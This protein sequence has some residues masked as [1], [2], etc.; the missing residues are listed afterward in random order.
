MKKILGFVCTI[1][2]FSNSAKSQEHDTLSVR[3]IWI[4]NLKEFILLGAVT[5]YDMK[6]TSILISDKNDNKG[7]K[8]VKKIKIG[9]SYLLDLENRIDFASPT[10]TFSVYHKDIIVWT[11][12]EPFNRQPRICLNCRGEYVKQLDQ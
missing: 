2:I 5:T 11:S 7:I 8:N 12:K 6:D 3:I 4:K 10:N 1:L 9:N